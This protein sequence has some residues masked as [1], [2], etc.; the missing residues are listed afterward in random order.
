LCMPTA[1]SREERFL[2]GRVLVISAASLA[3]GRA[4]TRN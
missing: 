2:D 4:R 3:G 1:L